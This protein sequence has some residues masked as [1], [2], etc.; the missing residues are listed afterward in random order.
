MR[1]WPGIENRT[2]VNSKRSASEHSIENR[3]QIFQLFFLDDGYPPSRLVVVQ[4]LMCSEFFGR[5]T[6]AC[7][8]QLL[9]RQKE[10]GIVNDLR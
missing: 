1:V 9:I 7:G 10:H 8:P 3:K 4:R 5:D 2:R 6:R